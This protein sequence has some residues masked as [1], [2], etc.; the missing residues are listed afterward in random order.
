MIENG[1]FIHFTQLY[2]ES[3]ATAL[4]IAVGISVPPRGSIPL[5]LSYYGLIIEQQ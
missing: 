4:M 1:V 5:K 2:L 3:C